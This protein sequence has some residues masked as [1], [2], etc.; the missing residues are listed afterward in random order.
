MSDETRET[1]SGDDILEFV[2]RFSHDKDAVSYY[3]RMNGWI[4][5]LECLKNEAD[6]ALSSKPNNKKEISESL[7]EI[8]TFRN[9]LIKVFI[10][11]HGHKFISTA[12]HECIDYELDGVDANE[13]VKTFRDYY[14]QFCKYKY[15]FYSRL[16]NFDPERLEDYRIEAETLEGFNDANEASNKKFPQLTFTFKLNT[17]KPYDLSLKDLEHFNA[18]VIAC[19][20]SFYHTSKRHNLSY[21]ADVLRDH[22]GRMTDREH[23]SNIFDRWERYLK[24]YDL[25]K[26]GGKKLAAIAEETK[27]I[28]KKSRYFHDE[29][30]AASA[31]NKDI[32]EAERLIIS[33]SKGTFPY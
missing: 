23:P 8:T 25:S 30:N 2:S 4:H 33:A 9:D 7:E 24:A 28:G 19:M 12:G 22:K 14:R 16:D 11:L 15:E 3:C 20:E 13:E 21:H 26:K 32:A 10:K 17:L 31:A 5:E 18:S 29:I 6:A 27:D 1:I